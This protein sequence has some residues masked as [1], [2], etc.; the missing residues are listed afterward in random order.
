M[1]VDNTV[2]SKAQDPGLRKLSD[3]Q[4]QAG[5][6]YEGEAPDHSLETA[7]PQEPGPESPV[8]ADPPPVDKEPEPE[9]PADSSPPVDK[10]SEPEP[11]VETNPPSADTSPSGEPETNPPSAD[12]SPPDT[13]PPGARHKSWGAAEKSY[14]HAQAK[15]T[16]LAQENAHLKKRLAARERAEAE[17][18]AKE[19]A[20]AR[21]QKVAERYEQAV[22]ALSELDEYD[23]D[24][25]HKAAKVWA[26]CHRDVN[27]IEPRGV[28][29][30]DVS[31]SDVSSSGD[32]S[33]A[34][35]DDPPGGVVPPEGPP[36]EPGPDP[37]AVRSRILARFSDQGVSAEDFGLDDPVFFAFASK[38][39]TVNDQGEALA[40]EAQVD[41]A[42]DQTRTHYQGMKKRLLQTAAQPLG[43]GA[44]SGKSKTEQRPAERTTLNSAVEKA[45]ARRVL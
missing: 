33:S 43:R 12:T 14:A 16:T 18:R 29:P 1:D 40:F 45:V 20:A 36:P 3:M 7:L 34:P 27:Q 13:S 44:V 22:A 2:V 42:I 24:Y 5:R 4:Q 19:L 6:V 28:T 8:E 15:M 21:E 9:P 38:A 17:A 37:E 39:P 30:T 23:P 10:E 25:K 31:S 35:A 26:D 32:H 41:W 11:P